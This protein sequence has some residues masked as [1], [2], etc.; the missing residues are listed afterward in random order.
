MTRLFRMATAVVLAF[1][2]LASGA[3]APRDAIALETWVVEFS[4]DG[5]NPGIC[6][7][8]REFIRFK[9]VDDVPRRVII[10]ANVQ[11]WDPLWDSGLVQPGELSNTFTINYGGSTQFVDPDSG[12]TM[13]ALTPVFVALWD[14]ECE[15]DPA[16]QPT[17]PLCR[18][19]LNCLRLQ[20]VAR[21]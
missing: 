13:T 1:G 21:D 14:P 5:F 4:E 3:L 18:E 2:A 15:V 9:N 12:K 20:Q 6:K 10:P 11:G 16:F 7:M 8:N 17:P 19:S